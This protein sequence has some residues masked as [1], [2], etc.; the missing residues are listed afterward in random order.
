MTAAQYAQSIGHPSSTSADITDS[1]AEKQDSNTQDERVPLPVSKR[2]AD[3]IS[4]VRAPPSKLWLLD[5]VIWCNCGNT[6]LQVV[7]C[8]F[9]WG[10]NRYD[11][12][13]WATGLFIALG[14][15]VAGVAGIVMFVEGKGVKRVEGVAPEGARD[16]ASERNEVAE[17]AGE[18]NVEKGPGNS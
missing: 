3:P 6:F 10:M 13:S 2:P 14:C 5:F 16:A 17:D 12:P 11:R 9:M 7:L 8:G 4:G 18:I 15:V 1:N